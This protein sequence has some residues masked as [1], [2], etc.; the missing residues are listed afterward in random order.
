MDDLLKTSQ[1]SEYT[2]IESLESVRGA[3]LGRTARHVQK[4][5]N[6]PELFSNVVDVS[7]AYNKI[8]PINVMN[9]N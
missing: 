6:Y 1:F 7:I 5:P 4:H 8:N 3:S 2:V 9:Y